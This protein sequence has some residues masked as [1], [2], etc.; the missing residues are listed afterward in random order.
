MT[1]MADGGAQ[2]PGIVIT[3]KDVYEEQRVS[4]H[5]LGRQISD[6]TTEVGRFGGQLG[7]MDSQIQN[8]AQMRADHEARL[9]ALERW[10]YALPLST[11]TAA[12]ALGLALASYLHH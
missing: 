10:R 3:L 1:I 9:R 5:D 4:A 8:G 11:L 12:G 7:A 6:L 2:I